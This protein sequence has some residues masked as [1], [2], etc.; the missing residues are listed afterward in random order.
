[1]FLL[2][3]SLGSKFE[4]GAEVVAKRFSSNRCVEP[5]D[6]S[7]SHQEKKNALRNVSFAKGVHEKEDENDED[8]NNDDDRGNDSGNDYFSYNMYRDINVK[9]FEKRSPSRLATNKPAYFPIDDPVT[10]TLTTSKY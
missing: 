1:M 10:R 7:P 2:V 8:E 5:P 4:A 9:G 6:S 3:S